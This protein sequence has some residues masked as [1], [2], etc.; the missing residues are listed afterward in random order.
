MNLKLL[1]VKLGRIVRFAIRKFLPLLIVAI[2]IAYPFL[3]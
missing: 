1:S 3:T 2:L